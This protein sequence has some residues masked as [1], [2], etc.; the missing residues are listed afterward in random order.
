MSMKNSPL[1]TIY[2]L[3]KDLSQIIINRI[4]SLADNKNFLQ[5]NSR[6]NVELNKDLE[7]D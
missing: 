4:H 1:G 2:T 7:Y 6:K 5:L 3:K